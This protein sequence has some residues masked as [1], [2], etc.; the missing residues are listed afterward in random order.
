MNPT[1]A[2]V[3]IGDL[4]ED[5][6]EDVTTILENYGSLSQK[7]LLK[8]VYDKYPAYTKKSRIKV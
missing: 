8:A 6:R 1:K 4:P 2:D 5:L 7:A 3:A